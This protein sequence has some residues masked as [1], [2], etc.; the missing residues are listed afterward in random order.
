MSLKELKKVSLS[1]S[2]MHQATGCKVLQQSELRKYKTL[3]ELFDHNRTEYTDSPQSIIILY[4]QTPEYGHWCCVTK[5]GNDVE[6][7]DPYGCNVNPVSPWGGFP[8]SELIFS[9]NNN[10]ELKQNYRYLAELMFKSPYNLFYNEHVFQASQPDINTCGRHVC[11]RI[12]NNELNLSQYK[13]TLDGLAKDTGF[14]YD[15]LV[16]IGTASV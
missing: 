7:F 8:D 14:N 15:D 9:K 13:K 11:F 1:D 3:E 6:F 10:A 2:Q 5:D 4:L 16:T 12:M